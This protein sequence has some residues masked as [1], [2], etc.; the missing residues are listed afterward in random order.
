MDKIDDDNPGCGQ[1]NDAANDQIMM[2]I[3]AMGTKI[4]KT[5]PVIKT[6]STEVG[7]S[8]RRVLKHSEKNLNVND[9]QKILF[10]QKTFCFDCIFRMANLHMA[11]FY[12]YSNIQIY[13]QFC[14]GGLLNFLFITTLRIMNIMFSILLV[15]NRE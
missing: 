7:E 11:D 1:W 6:I 5:N 9:L 13:S 8:F 12:C 3:L 2:T 4:T 15:D 14:N 10:L